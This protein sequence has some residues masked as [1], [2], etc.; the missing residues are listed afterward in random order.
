MAEDGASSAPTAAG[1]VKVPA[2]ASAP[3]QGLAEPAVA[4]SV[5]GLLFLLPVLGGLGFGAWQAQH[6]DRPLCS[7]ILRRA[8]QHLR[9][10]ETD[11]A[12]ERVDSLPSA[13]ELAQDGLLA[14]WLDACRRQ[15]YRAE[16]LSLARLC[17]RPA[18]LRWTATHLDVQLDL[19]HADIRVRRQGFDLNPGWLPWLGRVVS[20]SYEQVDAL[21]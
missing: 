1:A 7:P 17:R 12:W 10:A 14:A 4:T 8:L 6:T 11:P 9:V 16:R 2:S 5:G 19:R 13:A 20:F 21:P 18:R 15:L 3:L